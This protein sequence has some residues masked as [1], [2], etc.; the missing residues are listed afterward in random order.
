MIDVNI[1]N[2]PQ[3]KRAGLDPIVNGT[4]VP[5]CVVSKLATQAVGIVSWSYELA[6]GDC[7]NFKTFWTD[8]DIHTS[9]VSFLIEFVPIPLMSKWSKPVHNLLIHHST[10][11]CQQLPWHFGCLTQLTVCPFASRRLNTTADHISHA[12]MDGQISD[13][14]FCLVIDEIKKN[15]S[16][17]NLRSELEPGRHML[18][19]PSIE[20][21]KYTLIHQCRDE[22]WASLLKSWLHYELH[23]YLFL[24]CASHR[25]L[26]ASKVP[27]PPP[28]QKP[29]SFMIRYLYLLTLSSLFLISIRWQITCCHHKKM[30]LGYHRICQKQKEIFSQKTII[31][32][33]LGW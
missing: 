3:D 9:V 14:E 16:S 11:I 19:S 24:V 2:I 10:M 33:N 18:Q 21:A 6:P 22:A 25:S 31:A 23:L 8:S 26:A 7:I 13:E 29:G 15:I 30:W 20:E 12:L 32:P 1:H 5:D 4:A 27:P 17:Y 28:P